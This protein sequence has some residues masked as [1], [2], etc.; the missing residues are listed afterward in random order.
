MATATRT[1]W[2]LTGD[3]VAACNCAW[4]CPCQFDALPTHGSCHGIAAWA[5][6]QGYFGTTRLDGVRFAWICSWPGPIHEGNGTRLLIV[7]ETATPAQREGLIALHNGREGGALFEIFATVCPQVQETVFAPVSIEIDRE[8]RR[9]TVRVPRLLESRTEPI[10][11]P[12][13]G[14]EHRARIVL[15]DGFEYK[16]AEVANTAALRTQATEPLTF[17]HENTHSHLNQFDWSSG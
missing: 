16:E 4:G 9:A 5:V 10:R 1:E 6:R 8:R 13:T 11:N 15:P 3:E 14:E 17:Q 7:D 12:V 2:R